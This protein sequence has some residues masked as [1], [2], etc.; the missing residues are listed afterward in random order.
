MISHDNGLYHVKKLVPMRA[1]RNF[2]PASRLKR[3]FALWLRTLDEAADAERLIVDYDLCVFVP[4]TRFAWF[5]ARIVDLD[6]ENTSPL[7]LLIRRLSAQKKTE[8]EEKEEETTFRL[9]VITLPLIR[10]VN[11]FILAP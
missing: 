7:P 4:S 2:T 3:P 6:P 9:R 11:A 10:S 1:R 8:E 5:V